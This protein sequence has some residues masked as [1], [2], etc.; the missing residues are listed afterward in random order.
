M[1]RLS[2]P[3]M[4]AERRALSLV[5][6][7]VALIAATGLTAWF[8]ANFERQTLEV[9]VGASMEARRNPFLAAERFLARL[10]I[11]VE[12]VAGRDLLRQFPPTSDTLVVNGLGPL[13]PERQEALRAW[14]EGGGHLVV[15]AKETSEDGGNP[16]TCRAHLGFGSKR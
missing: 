9:P 8:F 4:H 3:A 6:A 16:T 5:I 12:S 11:P 1:T 7:G 10:G 14:I 13:N 15:E 2:V